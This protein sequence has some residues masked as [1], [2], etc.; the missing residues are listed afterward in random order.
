MKYFIYEIAMVSVMSGSAIAGT[1]IPVT[2]VPTFTP[3][4][5]VVTAAVL[6]VAGIYTLFRKR[7]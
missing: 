5:T 1:K 6:G 7:K 3:W 2:S 4:G